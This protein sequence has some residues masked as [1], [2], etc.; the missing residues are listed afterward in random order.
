MIGTPMQ[1]APSGWRCPIVRWHRPAMHYREQHHIWPKEHGGPSNGPLVGLCGGC[2]N[3]VHGLLAK[4][5]R[6]GWVLTDEL[7]AGS[8]RR[9]VELA[10]LG[11]GAITSRTLPAQPAWAA[12]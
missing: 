3:E 6:N 12:G 10:E 1:A 9:V 7:C 2:H 5:R 11:I 8:A 4:A